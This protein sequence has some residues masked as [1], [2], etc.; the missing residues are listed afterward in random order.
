LCEQDKNLVDSHIIPKSFYKYLYPEEKI[1]GKSL[2]MVDGRSGITKRS[3]IGPYEKLLCSECDG[4]I[5]RYDDYAKTIFLDS[6]PK[7]CPGANNAF[8]FEGIEYLNFKLFIVSLL[9]RASISSLD[10]FSRISLGP[11]EKILQTML[12]EQNPGS[13]ED[14]P[15]VVSKHDPGKLGDVANKNIQDPIKTRI[16]NINFYLFFLPRGYQVFIKVDSQ[17][18][19]DSFSGLCLK[20][21]GKLIVLN[22]GDYEKSG[23]Y[24]A[25]LNT[26]KS[27]KK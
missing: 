27:L 15:I 8:L 1:E 19:P 22:R 11:Y 6:T 16:D 5:G 21:D 26:A 12:K 25:L 14:F 9:W 3:R 4:A 13:P 7:N 23:S 18:L 17:K 2:E 10:I 20:N 24:K